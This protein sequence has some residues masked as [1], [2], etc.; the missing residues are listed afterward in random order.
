MTTIIDHRTGITP[1]VIRR[2]AYYASLGV[3]I[4]FPVH[5][6]YE[7]VTVETLYEV[8]PNPK[9]AAEW[10]FGIRVNFILSG[11]VTRWVEF[12][13]R[14]VGAGGDDILRKVEVD[15]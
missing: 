13:S 7:R 3:G 8:T 9:D 1:I 12:S 15:E 4:Y 6:H 2:A 10:A 5:P 11:R 14:L